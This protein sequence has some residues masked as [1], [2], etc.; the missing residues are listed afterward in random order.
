MNFQ[1]RREI[2]M[3]SFCVQA[4][5][6]ELFPL[7]C[8]QREL[9][10]L[11]GWSYNMVYSS[12]GF[13]EQDCVFKTD[14]AVEGPAVWFATQ[15]Q[16]PQI[17]EYVKIAPQAL[18]LRMTIELLAIAADVTEVSVTCSFTGLTEQGNQCIEQYVAELYPNRMKIWQ[19]SLEQYFKKRKLL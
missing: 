15:H 4:K 16:T 18:A 1:A 7:F 9:E 2:R 13:S 14:N 19:Q 5:R 11:E 10:W 3:Y 12:T 8:P 17:V 6:A